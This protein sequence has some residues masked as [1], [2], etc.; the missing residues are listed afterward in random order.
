MQPLSYTKNYF[1][2]FRSLLLDSGGTAVSASPSVTSDIPLSCVSAT[3]GG[4]LRSS[5]SLYN[6]PDFSAVSLSTSD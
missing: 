3:P 1:K 6:H 2:L 5:S 4:D